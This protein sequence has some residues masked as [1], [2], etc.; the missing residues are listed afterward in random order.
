MFDKAKKMWELQGKA[1]KLQREL[2]DMRFTGEE[3]GGKVK[4]TL[5]GEQKVLAIEID[6]SLINVE[7]KEGLIKF[8]GQAFT[9]AAKKSQQAAANRTKEIVG[10]LGIPGL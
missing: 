5:S 2:R 10:G 3:L 9:S 8:L 1:K 7:E 4:V 6:D